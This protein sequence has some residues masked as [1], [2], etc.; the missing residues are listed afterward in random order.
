MPDAIH[1]TSVATGMPPLQFAAVAQ[2][3][4]DAPIKLLVHAPTVEVIVVGSE[5]VSLPVL[6]SLPPETTTVLVTEGG[7]L[8]DT[9]TVSVITGYDVPAARASE[10]VHVKLPMEQ[11]QPAPLMVVAVRP[12]GRES[13]RLTV[14]MVGPPPLLVTVM[15]YCAPVCP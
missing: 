1:A 10:R 7:A 2:V 13:V 3:P 6:V 5:A 9:L 14:P 8:V 11:A 15:M 12:A 4:P